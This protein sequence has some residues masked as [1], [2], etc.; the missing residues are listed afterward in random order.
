MTSSYEVRVRSIALGELDDRVFTVTLKGEEQRAARS[1]AGG[2]PI[3]EKAMK[4]EGYSPK[5]YKVYGWR[6]LGGVSDN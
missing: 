5:E 2:L 4:A 6:N 3:M 1:W